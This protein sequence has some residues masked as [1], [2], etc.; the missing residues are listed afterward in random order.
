MYENEP[1]SELHAT[2]VNGND[3]ERD[4]AREELHRRAGYGGD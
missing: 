3:F 2:I 4:K 1:L